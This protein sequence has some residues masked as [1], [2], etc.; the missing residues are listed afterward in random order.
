[1]RKTYQK[2]NEYLYDKGKKISPTA[3][4]GLKSEPGISFIAVKYKHLLQKPHTNE[5]T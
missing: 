1:M 2:K 3:G 4:L 5:N